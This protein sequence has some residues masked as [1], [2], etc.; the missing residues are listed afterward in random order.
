MNWDKVEG[1]WKQFKGKAREQWGKLT[2]SDWEK[3]AG[4][5]DQLVGSI[6]RT[7]GVQKDEAERQVDEFSR[8]LEKAQKE[9]RH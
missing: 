8:G 6:Q 1:N 3:I 9:A 4:K 7:Y 2:D 5:R